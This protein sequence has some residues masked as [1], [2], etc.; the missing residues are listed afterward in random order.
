MRKDVLICGLALGTSTRQ[1]VTASQAPFLGD[2]A[3]REASNKYFT[4]P[5]EIRRVAVIGGGPSGLQEAAA[6][7]EHG[8]E[9]R[10]FERK[11]NPGGAWYY[12]REKPVSAS[13]SWVIWVHLY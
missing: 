8:F 5:Y 12:Q 9:V 6:L 4:F 1:A 3:G 7:V 11:P 2:P 10:L 13:F